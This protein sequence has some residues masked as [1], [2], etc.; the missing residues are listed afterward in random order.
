[1]DEGYPRQYLKIT[2]KSSRFIKTGAFWCKNAPAGFFAVDKNPRDGLIESSEGGDYMAVYIE[3]FVLPSEGQESGV[4]FSEN[5]TCFSSFYPFRIFPKKE[6]QKAEFSPVTIFYGGNGSGKSTMLNL[7]AEKAGLKRFSAFGKSAFFEKYLGFCKIEYREKITEESSLL[8]S[9]DVFDY[10]LD[11]RN[12]NNGI[13]LRREELFRD[14][15]E[16]KWTESRLRSMEDY[17]DWK[18]SY[19][20][21]RKTQSKFVK[22]R[23]MKNVE[24]FSNGESALKYFVD[25]IDK[26]GVYLLDEPENSLSISLQLELME[27]LENSARF[28]GCQFIIASHSPVFLSI[29]GAKIYDLDSVPVKT[30]KWTEL[31]NVRK[32]RDFFKAHES[33]FEDPED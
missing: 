31:E 23:L 6:F 32:F 4:L 20:A 21:K 7:V 9:D 28:F 2:E 30:K 26:K 15:S 16:R 18:E 8:S 13:D 24:M 33:E 3:K 10:L 12:I 27:Y 19:D 1:M 17:H 29:P 22:D 5:R 14:F 11:I 25:K